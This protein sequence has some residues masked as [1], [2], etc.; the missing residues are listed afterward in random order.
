M[1]GRG[2]D[3]LV[4]RHFCSDLHRDVRFALVVK[5]NHFVLVLGFGVG[6]P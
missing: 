2:D 4:S 6:V 1:R 3:V 5:N